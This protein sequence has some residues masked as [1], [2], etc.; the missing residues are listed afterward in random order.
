MRF[1]DVDYATHF[2]AFSLGAVAAF[3][4]G[5]LID[6]LDY[7]YEENFGKASAVLGFAFFI[8]AL[9]T[10][11][12]TKLRPIVSATVVTAPYLL[13]WLVWLGVVLSYPGTDLTPTF[14]SDSEFLSATE[15]RTGL[16]WEVA[17]VFV[18]ITAATFG[19]FSSAP[20]RRFIMKQIRHRILQ[21]G[22]Q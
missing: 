15:R 21:R 10:T 22:G 1:L 2:V 8:T 16:F 12:F 9:V 5:A 19:A 18:P 4:S 11:R 17:S 7:D 14:I 20:L 6:S 13:L 3:A